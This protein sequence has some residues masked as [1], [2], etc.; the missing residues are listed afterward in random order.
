MW[1]FVCRSVVGTSHRR[2]GLPCQDACRAVT[3]RANEA[4]DVLILVCADGA[5]SAARADVGAVTACDALAASAGADLKEGLPVSEVERD[6][7]L[8]W[9]DKVR[10]E[11]TANADLALLT[12]RD[13]ACTLLL[14]VVGA[15]AAAFAQ[16]GDGAFVVGDGG[17][18][19]PVFWPQ[20]GEYANTTNFV[21]DPAYADN[22]AFERRPGRLDEV[23]LLTDGLQRLALDFTGKTAHRPFF[24][25]LFR[26]LRAADGDLT[27]ALAQF[28]N[29]PRVNQRSDDDKT[30]ILAARVVSDAAPT[31]AL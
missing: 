5:G 7:V 26:Q 22:L 15:D 28:L 20:S 11:L 31:H 1:K 27:V 2:D 9:F 17:E 21:T 3:V 30:L 18:Y 29:S 13:L 10:Q 6:T 4:E 19:R 25:P 23:A 24:E 8:Y 16:V 14:A 12:P